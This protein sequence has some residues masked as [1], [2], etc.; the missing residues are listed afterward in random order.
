[1]F[2]ISFLLAFCIFLLAISIINLFLSSAIKL[3]TN[4]KLDEYKFIIPSVLYLIINGITFAFI[5][6][7]NINILDLSIRDSIMAI[8]FKTIDI[9]DKLR[10]IVTL[11]LI[12]ISLSIIIQSVC[13]MTVNID[14]TVS[15]G[16]IR[17]LIKDFIKLFSKKPVKKDSVKNDNNTNNTIVEEQ[18]N[19]AENEVDTEKT[20]SD[21][22]N[23]AA[24][25]PEGEMAENK[26]RLKLTFGNSII[27]TLFIFAFLFFTFMALF[28]L[29]SVISDKIM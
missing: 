27:C 24:V 16:K 11:D 18:I 14:Y 6:T 8:I 1:M 17:M 10:T 13:L 23:L 15:F 29:G 20:K 4:N 22:S 3:V 26:E 5:Y 7:T 25:I 21:V 19:I 28:T 12:I 9:S 2:F